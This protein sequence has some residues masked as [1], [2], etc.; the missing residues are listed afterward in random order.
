MKQIS[1]WLPFAFLI[2]AP[3]SVAQVE[4]S[5]G[6]VD[7][8]AGTMDIYMTNDV[9]VAGFQFNVKDLSGVADQHDR[10]WFWW[11]GG[12]CELLRRGCSGDRSWLLV[13]AQYD[14][15]LW[16]RPRSSY[17]LAPL[18]ATHRMYAC[19]VV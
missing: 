7:V 8:S 11:H 17:T 16:W 14:S 4:L 12:H 6:N 3:V 13:C 2:I 9:P 15:P 1:F 5:V 18:L 10:L 19:R